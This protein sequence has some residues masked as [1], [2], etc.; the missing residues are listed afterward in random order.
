MSYRIRPGRIEDAPLLGPMESVA[1]RRFG[2]I[3]LIRIAQG[4]PTVET[5]YV[6]LA[7]A[8]RLWVAEEEEGVPVGLVI[9]GVV[10]GEGYLA[11]VSVHPDYGRQGLGRALI[12]TVEA[13]SRAQGFTK[14]SL[15]TFR[16][17]AW[18]RPYYEG[19]GFSVLAEDEAGP[20]LRTIREGERARGVDNVSPR[21]C[22]RKDL[23]AD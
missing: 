21:V 3:G 1:A 13:W 19:L 5:E 11:E 6:D 14:L 18:N 2:E 16:D 7:Q 15:T 9:A 12:G 23:S 4:R 20:E 10:D 22:M 8:H 17:V